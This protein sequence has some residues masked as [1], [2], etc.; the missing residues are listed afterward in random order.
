MHEHERPAR[1]A[2]LS[3]VACSL[4][5]RVLRGSDWIEADRAIRELRTFDFPAPVRLEP[6]LCDTC[7][8]IVARRRANGLRDDFRAAA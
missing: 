7:V 6:A 2:S 1:A 8:E 3:F 4:C 5:L